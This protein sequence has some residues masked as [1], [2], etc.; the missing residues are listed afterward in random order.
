MENLN[1]LGQYLFSSLGHVVSVVSYDTN[2]LFELLLLLLYEYSMRGHL[3]SESSSSSLGSLLQQESG[4]RIGTMRQEE[5][6]D[7]VHEI[8]RLMRSEMGKVE[9]WRTILYV[10]IISMAVGLV[11]ST[12]ALLRRSDTAVKKQTV[13]KWTAR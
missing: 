4:S 12:H 10:F 9:T 11:G 13:R 8:M 6:R 5:D 1:D 2:S 3:H 7:E